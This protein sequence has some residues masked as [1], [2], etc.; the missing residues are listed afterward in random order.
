M[1][2]DLPAPLSPTSAITSPSRTSKSTSCKARTEP[3]CLETPRSSRV[4][5]VVVALTGGLYHGRGARNGAPR[6]DKVLLAV[7]RVLPDANL[8]PLQ[9]LVL[10]EELEI[11]LRDPHR[12]QQDRRRAADLMAH[13]FELLGN[14]RQS[15]LLVFDDRNGD[16]GCGGRFPPDRLVHGSGLPAGEDEL[17]AGGRRVLAGQRN[18]LEMVLLQRRDHGAGETVIRRE[19]AVDLVAVAGE[20]LIEDRPSLDGIPVRPLVAGGRLLERA[21]LVERIEDRVV[22]LLEQLRVIVLDIAVQLRDH[23]VLAVC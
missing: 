4:G 1:S 14:G 2:V 17:D 18:L 11:R 6:P 7:L 9:E 21:G 23:R 13:A 20:H 15:D 12:S 22:P 8:A 19:D 3:K 10:E 16:C 5:A